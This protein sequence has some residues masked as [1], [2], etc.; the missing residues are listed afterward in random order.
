V[1]ERRKRMAWAHRLL[2]G[3]AALEGCPGNRS[4]NDSNPAKFLEARSSGQ[5]AGC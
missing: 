3:I 1:S 4:E 2:G 5:L